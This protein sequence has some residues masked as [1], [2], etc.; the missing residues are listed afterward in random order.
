MGATVNEWE[1]NQRIRPQTADG[2]RQVVVGRAFQPV[3]QWTA[4]RGMDGGRTG[5]P[6]CRGRGQTVNEWGTNQRI[7]PR[8][9]DGRR[10]VVVGRAFQPVRQWTA[11][12]GMDGGRTGF[13]ACR[14][15]GQTVNEW[16]TNQ[17]IRPQ[18]AD[19]R[20]QVVVG[21]AFQPVRQ[22]TADCG[23]DGGRTGFPACQRA[24]YSPGRAKTS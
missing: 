19:G 4:D 7:R 17:R 6:A 10:Q 20:R 11:D 24:G 14:G 13:P 12:R 21:R 5:F 22:W 3:R 8:T 23:M 15:M 18:T 2:R 9:A 1:T 16:G